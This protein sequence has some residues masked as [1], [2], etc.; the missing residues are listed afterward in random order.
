MLVLLAILVIP[1]VPVMGA[2]GSFNM[3]VLQG[4]VGTQVRIY[5]DGFTE[6]S[7]YTIHFGSTTVSPLDSDNVIQSGGVFDNYFIVPDLAAGRYSVWVTTEADTSP[8]KYF[9]I[10]SDPR[11][12]ISSTSGYVGDQV[13]V[14]GSSF[15]AN[16]SAQIRFDG[17]SVGS[18]VS[19]DSNGTMPGT[20]ITI[21][22]ATGGS[23]TFT[24]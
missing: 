15:T 19:I 8:S 4:S 24:A 3:S 9:T 10:V 22:D 11:I 7:Y 2:T 23:H 16:S 6:D 5:G 1:V 20:V 14:S 18:S 17:N 13:T 21:P 12:T